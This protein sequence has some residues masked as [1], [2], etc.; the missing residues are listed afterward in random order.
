MLVLRLS[1]PV[2]SWIISDAVVGCVNHNHLVVLVRSV[3]RNPITVKH[4]KASDSSSDSFFGLRSQ[5]SGGFQL[6]DTDAGGFSADD[7]L[8][9]WSLPATP[10]D[11]NPVDDVAVLGLVAEF[12][13]FVGSGWFVGP[14]DDGHLP[15]LPSSDS[16]DEGH[17]IRLL[18]P[19][20][21]FQI[22]VRTH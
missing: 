21:L 7:T 22:F 13:G 10:S 3:L 15:V 18:L 8:G 9:D 1:D 12:S 20:Y 16:E 4:T 6:V 17:D 19:P 5:V 2:Y 11:S 14:G